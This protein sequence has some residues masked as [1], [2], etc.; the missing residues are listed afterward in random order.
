M[1]EDVKKKVILDTSVLIKWLVSEPEDKKQA[2][3]LKY[4]F[5]DGKIKVTILALTLWELN[6]HIGRL[7]D[8]DESAELFSHFQMYRLIQALLM[9]STALLGFQIMKDCPG[10]SFCDASYHAL[11]IQ[12]K[13]IFITSDNKYYEKARKLGHI[14][15]LKN[16]K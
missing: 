4:E 11:A 14:Q 2:D 5:L 10:V 3:R 15:L 12:T 7:F 6:N 1:A 8:V 13:A 16:Y 9:P